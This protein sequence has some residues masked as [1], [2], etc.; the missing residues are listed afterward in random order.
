MNIRILALI[1][2]FLSTSNRTISQIVINEIFATNVNSFLE[3]E[4]FNFAGFIELYNKGSKTE[5][6]SNFYVSNK[7]DQLNLFMLPGNISIP[8]KSYYTIYCDLLNTRNHA[9]FKLDAD[10]GSV[11]LCT[12]T[13]NF[14]DS[15][16]Y[17][18]QYPDIAYGR[19]PDGTGNWY[20][21][22]NPTPQ[23]TNTTAKNSN[24][25]C[26]KPSIN[27][28]AGF[29]KGAINISI[30][31]SP[32]NGQ[33][34]FTT[35]GSEPTSNS[36]LYKGPFLTS[37]S[38]VVKAKVFHNNFLTS[39]TSCNTYLINEHDSNLPVVSVSTDP[40]YLY[41]DSIGI[42]VVGKNGI[43]GNCTGKANYNRDWERPGFFEY[44]TED[45]KVQ[46]SL[47]LDIKISGGCSRNNSYQK[48]LGLSPSS[49]YGS[50]KFNYEFFKSRPF[51]KDYGSLML[52][53]AGNDWTKTMFR[54]AVEQEIV[55]SDMDVDYQAYQPVAVYLNGKY[56]GLLNLREKVN[57][58]YLRGSYGLSPD[59]V[60]FLEKNNQV[61][62][63]SKE[64]YVHFI[65]S[66]NKT[67]M[68][69]DAAYSLL[70]RNIDINEYLNYLV[71][72]IYYANK[73]W[74]GN[75]I[76]Y[77]KSK[78][79]G[80]K[81]RWILTD[82]DF[83]LGANAKSNDST[84]YFVTKPDGTAWPNPA[85]STLLPRK[86]FE[87]PIT[88]ALFIQKMQTAI[89]TVFTD[90][91]V[92][93]KID[94]IRDYTAPEMTYHWT[95][96][97]GNSTTWNKN[98]DVMRNFNKSRRDFMAWHLRE[99]FKLTDTCREV[100]LRRPANGKVT[101]M[102]NQIEVKDTMP[103]EF[104]PDFPLTIEAKP[105]NGYEFS[106]WNCRYFDT[107]KEELIKANSNWMYYDGNPA[108]TDASWKSSNYNETGWKSGLAEFGY[109]DGDENTLINYGYDAAN[110]HITSYFR[111]KFTVSNS[112]E[113]YNMEGAI[114]Y[115]DGAIVY[116]NG[117][118][119]FRVN[120][121][122]TAIMYSTP[123]VAAKEDDDYFQKFLI[124][125]SLI[126]T[127]ENIIA[128][129]IHQNAAN[130]SD[131]SFDFKLTA[132]CKDYK[133]TASFSDPVLTGFYPQSMELTAVMKP[134]LA[135][136]GL[137][138]NEVSAL[139]ST[140]PDNKGEDSNWIEIFNKGNQTIPLNKVLI[141]FNG[142]REISWPLSH[143]D[144][145]FIAPGQFKVFWADNEL[146]EGDSHLP[147]K[148]DGENAII[149]L[150]QKT[151]DIKITMDTFN[152]SGKYYNAT[153][154]RYPDGNTGLYFMTSA[155]PG[156]QNL[157]RLTDG[158]EITDEKAIIVYPNPARDHMYI[159]LSNYCDAHISATVTDQQGRE[160]L[161]FTIE[162]TLDEINL[163]GLRQGSYILKIVIGDKVFYKKLMIL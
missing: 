10:G 31:K 27:P 111:K 96:F 5:N 148:F 134:D 108:L 138:F 107:R 162:N 42:Y 55:F 157:Y 69:S 47:G 12:N 126:K 2:L 51:V 113:V 116:L 56:F 85:W 16:K 118:E 143:S 124:P 114:L 92:N 32:E 95:R 43:T 48:S 57:K 41:D 159:Q 75:N 49:R 45:G 63:G 78:R 61:I 98:I 62:A 30:E 21:L 137:V 65:D 115:D 146:R 13:L 80:S 44:F 53:N 8:A 161:R 130:S 88:R 142:N 83:G 82:L 28:K 19:K 86:I 14:V 77:W 90:E 60:H 127:G 123:A 23:K 89:N 105:V 18:R 125:A 54:D 81:W 99:F 149:R 22:G 46:E 153:I 145:S 121:P 150:T 7:K 147:F 79:P 17:G 34:R 52:R 122:N 94:S 156:A 91:H 129:E 4:T 112:S 132:K 76:K 50:G 119:V 104:Y 29:Y 160:R 135:Y 35:D 128:V 58:N 15:V 20:R 144:T 72:Q 109:G 33:I 110:K 74:P 136:T 158:N 26:S 71:I 3:K 101:Y 84:L 39:A 102:L 36:R 66:L 117:Q 73:D 139:S 152:V 87:N 100:I 163:T 25:I 11:Y 131:L 151:G 140:T 141:E 155:T 97:T 9:N 59:S 6:I 40:K 133:A 67:D 1:F 37:T 120:M 103:R 106:N 93:S 70:D 64:S 154:G 68:T 24:V 38:I